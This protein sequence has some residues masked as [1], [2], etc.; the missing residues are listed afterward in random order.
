MPKIDGIAFLKELRNTNLDL[1]VVILSGYSTFEYARQGIVL[2]AF[3]YLLKPIENSKLS[4]V[5]SRVR[6]HLDEKYKSRENQLKISKQLE[7]SIPTPIS[8][9]DELMLFKLIT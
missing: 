5:L 1:C 6:I 4:E 9:Q 3:D 7:E 8:K 2:G